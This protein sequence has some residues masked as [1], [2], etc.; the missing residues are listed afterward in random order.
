MVYIFK[1]CE[2][3]VFITKTDF[4]SLKNLL[5]AQRLKMAIIPILFSFPT[6]FLY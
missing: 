4:Y 1:Y 6:L 5:S 2:F 3:G